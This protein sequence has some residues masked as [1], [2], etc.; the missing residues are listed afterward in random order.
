MNE[1]SP[2]SQSS[3]TDQI[4]SSF[5]LP[6]VTLRLKEDQDTFTTQYPGRCATIHEATTVIPDGLVSAYETAMNHIQVSED[7]KAYAHIHCKALSVTLPKG[8]A[9]ITK[10]E[11]TVPEHRAIRIYETLMLYS[12][13]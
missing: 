2:P 9:G 8:Y 11:D 5:V 4:K 10:Y 3:S 13:K 7:A 6:T 1:T 12:K